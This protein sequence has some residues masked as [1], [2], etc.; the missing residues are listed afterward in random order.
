MGEKLKAFKRHVSISLNGSKMTVS[1]SWVFPSR[2]TM[3]K[4]RE[5]LETTE[6]GIPVIKL[7][8]AVM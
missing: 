2:P 5:I 3:R 1:G 4:V 6:K 7:S 8:L